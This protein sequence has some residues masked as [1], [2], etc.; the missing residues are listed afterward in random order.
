MPILAHS[1]RSSTRRVS[2]PSSAISAARRARN[3]GV[4]TL[5]GSLTRSRARQVASAAMRPMRTPSRA[6]AALLPVGLEHGQRADHLAVLLLQ[7]LVEAIGAEQGALRDR[8]RPLAR[9]QPGG[10]HEHRD[11]SGAKIARAPHRGGGG[12][13]NG[14]GV[15]GPRPPLE[16]AEPDHQHALGRD[17]PRGME[18]GDLPRLA[19]ELLALLHAR[20][21]AAERPVQRDDLRR[22]PRA[23]TVLPQHQHVRARFRW[24]SGLEG[25]LHCGHPPWDRVVGGQRLTARRTMS[26]SP[27]VVS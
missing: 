19:L 2:P 21:Q 12:A 8:L 27:S 13:A 17:R 3:V 14:L 22:G 6:A 24:A 7:V 15:A 1:A 20:E 16:R 25:Q 18:V 11:G 9:G 26:A 10:G 23:V 4:T 5:A